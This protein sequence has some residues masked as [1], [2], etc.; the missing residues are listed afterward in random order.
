[1]NKFFQPNGDLLPGLEWGDPYRR[2][3]IPNDT[4]GYQE[5][6]DGEPT[7]ALLEAAKKMVFE[8]TANPYSIAAQLVHAKHF[9]SCTKGNYST[10]YYW[11]RDP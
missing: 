9:A 4:I 2:P 7:E 3:A 1:M 5:F 10:C 6:V 11:R 8:G